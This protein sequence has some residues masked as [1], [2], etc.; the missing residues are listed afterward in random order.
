VKASIDPD[1]SMFQPMRLT[2]DIETPSDLAYLWNLFNM[3]L[4]K[5]ED[6]SAHSTVPYTADNH[7]YK[8]FAQRPW[9]LLDIA[10]EKFNMR[11]ERQSP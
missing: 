6:Q 11:R 1:P 9:A 10:V 4:A 8:V 7:H 5:V 3:S 2:I